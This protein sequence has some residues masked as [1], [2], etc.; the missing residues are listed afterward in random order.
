MDITTVLP[1][2]GPGLIT[3]AVLV[4]LW[5]VHRFE[6]IDHADREAIKPVSEQA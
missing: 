3:G 5:G 6:A 1:I 2:A 4:L